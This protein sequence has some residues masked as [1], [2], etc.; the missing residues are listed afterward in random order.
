MAFASSPASSNA[1]ESSSTSGGVS[2]RCSAR[3]AAVRIAVWLGFR[4]P[5]AANGVSRCFPSVAEFYPSLGGQ[6][7]GVDPPLGLGSTLACGV[8]YGPVPFGVAIFFYS[9]SKKA[10]TSFTN[11]AGEV[12]MAACP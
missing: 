4:I 10:S 7:D 9:P 1:S 12:S 6:H 11:N 3:A 5:G 8:F 2:S